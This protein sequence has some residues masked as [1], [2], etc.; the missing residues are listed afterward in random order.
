M[1][2]LE[3]LKTD[4]CTLPCGHVLHYACMRDAYRGGHKKCPKC[5]KAI[6][7]EKQITKIYF[8]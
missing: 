7:S 1:L 8:G 3:A 4:L 5:R 6:K 2:C